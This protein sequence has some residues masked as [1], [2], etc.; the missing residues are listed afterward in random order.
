MA[1]KMRDIIKLGVET[2][3]GTLA[4][5]MA[6]TQPFVGDGFRPVFTAGLAPIQASG[7]FPYDTDAVP[8]GATVAGQLTPE[9]NIA[10]IRDLVLLATKRT[11][12]ALPAVSIQHL[13]Q[14]ISGS[15]PQM[16]Y[17]G[18]VCRELQLGFSRGASPG[19]ENILT[20]SLGFE[21][22]GYAVATGLSGGT[23]ATGHHF[24]IRNTTFTLNAV[25]ALEVLGFQ[26]TVSNGLS[27]GPVDSANARLWIEEGMEQTSVS[28]TARLASV[29][30]RDLIRAQT[31]FAATI[32]LGTGTSN[33]TVTLTMGK[34]QLSSRTIAEQDGV[35]TE[36]ITLVP[37][38]TGAAA[39][40]VWTFGSS[41][42]ATVLS[43]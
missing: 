1:Q 6:L 30:Y 9:I 23:Q 28:L 24:Q 21:F 29:D 17:L 5:S 33:E 3:R 35:L 22:Y 37:F 31:E 36:Q 41:I 40:C 14:S 11:S 43:L 19:G 7:T 27:L 39:P 34:V 2:T 18:G 10:T 25:V 12:A 20:G 13:H 26:L 32:V 15:N 38:Y 4:S 42:G 16:S 8:V